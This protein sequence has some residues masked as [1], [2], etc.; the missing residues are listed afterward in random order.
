MTIGNQMDTYVMDRLNRWVV[1]C[2]W[3]A[4]LLTRSPKPGTVKSWWFAMVTAPNVRQHGRHVEELGR[5]P[6]DAI[7]AGATDICVRAL[8][9]ELRAAIVMSYLTSGT[10]EQKAARLG[11][12]RRKFFYVLKQAYGE[13]LGL[14]NDYEAGIIRAD[15]ESF[16]EERR[17]EMRLTS[18]HS[19]STIRATLV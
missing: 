11:C 8:P 6:V 7:E 3:R 16:N 19:R 4:D 12:S 15:V 17:S 5:C 18:L 13:L 1:F 14:F 10:A 2:L 9:S